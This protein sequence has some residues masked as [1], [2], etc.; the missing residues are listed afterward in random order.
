[1]SRSRLRID[2]QPPRHDSFVPLERDPLTGRPRDFDREHKNRRQ[3]RRPGDHQVPSA[4]RPPAGPPRLAN[5]GRR[6]IWVIAGSAAVTAAVIVGA[7]VLG[8][9][10]GTAGPASAGARASSVAGSS[11]GAGATTSSSA[12]SGLPTSGSVAGGVRAGP[13]AASASARASGPATS[14]SAASAGPGPSNVGPSPSQ[15]GPTLPPYLDPDRVVGYDT[16]VTFV[17]DRLG[18]KPTYRQGVVE[19]DTAQCSPSGCSLIVGGTEYT[20]VPFTVGTP[21]FH[22]TH[23]ITDSS[24]ASSACGSTQTFTVDLTLDKSTGDYRGTFTSVPVAEVGP[25]CQAS[26]SRYTFALV[27]VI[28]PDLTAVPAGT[29]AALDPRVIR[30]YRGSSAS[31]GSTSAVEFGCSRGVCLLRCHSDMCDGTV[32]VL[33]GAD[34]WAVDDLHPDRVTCGRGTTKLSMVRADDGSYSG[35]V[36]ASYAGPVDPTKCPATMT[37]SLTPITS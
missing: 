1:M 6:R 14:V 23:K 16:V 10:A 27:P 9:S 17:A 20:E 13:I 35:S 37:L 18:G 28:T 12:S 22:E 4:S 31:G 34:A 30:G 26:F 29:P 32:A 19:H 8:T 11:P 3:D 21:R 15:V 24:E 25:N 36:T 7:V 2:D 5:P 33:A